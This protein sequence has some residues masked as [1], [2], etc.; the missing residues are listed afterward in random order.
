MESIKHDRNALLLFDFCLFFQRIK[1]IS[2]GSFD[3]FLEQ[4]TSKTPELLV[5]D[6]VFKASY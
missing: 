2:N 3:R 5:I 4:K 6:S 1:W